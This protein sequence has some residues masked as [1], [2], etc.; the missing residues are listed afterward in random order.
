MSK[1]A[2]VIGG[3]GGLDQAV[4]ETLGRKS[5]T[6]IVSGRNEKEAK[7]QSQLSPPLAARP[8]PLVATWLFAT[9]S[10]MFTL[11]S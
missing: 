1:I 8:S 10:E 11:K 9:R 6:V 7:K 4:S 3:T 2:L 5:Y